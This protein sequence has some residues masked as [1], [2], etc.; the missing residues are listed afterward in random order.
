MQC[1]NISLRFFD[2][3]TMPD[4]SRSPL[5]GAQADAEH[6]RSERPRSQK[7]GTSSR[8]KHSNPSK[9]SEESTPLLSPKTNHRDYGDAPTHNGVG[10]PAASSLRSLQNG[11]SSKGNKSRRWPTIVALTILGLVIVVILCLGFAAPAVV[12]EYA[13]QAMVFEPT[14]LSVDSFTSTGVRARIQGDFMLDGSR[15]ERKA[16]RDLGRAGTWIARA[17]E[18]KR[19]KVQVYLP[20]YD[21][22]L[23]GTADVPPV[24]VDVRDG[25]TTHIDFLSDLAAGDLDGIRRMANDWIEGIISHLSVRGVADVPLKSGI[26]SLGTQSLAQTIV[27]SGSCTPTSCAPARLKSLC[28][29][30][31]LT[32]GSE[33]PLMPQ[34]NITKLNFHEVD[35]PRSER[36][37][38]A[39]VSLVLA[40]E[41]PFTF[42][43]P[44]L[45]FD[46]LVRG[47]SPEEP[48][49]RLADATTEQISVEPKEDIK[50]QVGGFIQQIPETLLAICPQTEKS[51]LDALLGD[52]IRGDETTI[53]VRGSNAPSGD[54]PNWVTDLI[55]SV[56]L[57][58][59]FPGKTFEGMIRNFS[60]ADVHFS[61]PDP[62]ASPNEPGA[63]PRISAIVKAIVGLPKEMNF[64]I[65]VPRVRADADV[66]YHKK[67]LGRL[68]L[69]RWQKANSTRIEA[70]GDVEAGLAVNSVVKNAPLKITDDDVF[71]ELVSDMVFGG[72][73][74]ILGV[75]ANV[76]VETETALGKFVVRDIP[77]EG[78]VPVKR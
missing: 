39:D 6:S 8:S 51:P 37:M 25:H 26:F 38:E 21:D 71:S 13:K 47:C 76:D 2:F 22:L 52:Y 77:A 18:S 32:V 54:T 7:S 11:G 70:D 29:L 57:P 30:T 33:I 31:E 74:V 69:N 73:K 56:T 66:F 65:E 41:Y 34:Y 44:P 72:K 1:L 20:E 27:F 9:H 49:I 3:V 10:S 61:L 4:E 42:T 55:K 53:F 67:K 58:L 62:F 40:N 5:L 12:E 36:G 43:V 46:V 28:V 50:I 59:P 23:L 15:V 63:S 60:L 64:P 75:K 16:V 17:V 24:V 45:G 78:K 35:L 68:D 19:S 48:Y 14:A